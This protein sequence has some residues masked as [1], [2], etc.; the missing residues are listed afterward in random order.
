MR[1]PEPHRNTSGRLC[2]QEES[3]QS[4]LQTLRINDFGVAYGQSVQVVAFTYSRDNKTHS[5]ILGAELSARNRGYRR[6]SAKANT[7]SAV[8]F[9]DG[10]TLLTQGV[11]KMPCAT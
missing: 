8:F 11:C 5:T 2:S 7:L 10:I 1:P 9:V 3:S 6:L 4:R